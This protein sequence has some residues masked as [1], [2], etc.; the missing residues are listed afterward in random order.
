MATLPNTSSLS[1]VPRDTLRE[2]GVVVG[3][4]DG[5]TIDVLLEDGKVYR[6][7]YIGIDT[8]D[9][10]DPGYSSSASVNQDL[11]YGKKVT[12]VKDVSNIDKYDRLLRYVIVGDI[13]VNYEIVYKGYAYSRDY[14][15]DLAC[16][17]TFDKAESYANA[18]NLGMWAPEPTALPTFPSRS[19]GVGDVCSCSG[20]IYNCSDFS[21]HSQAQACYDYCKDQGHG[22]VHRLDSDNDGSACETLP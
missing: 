17:A 19:G 14:Y 11:V 22:D 8:P 7:R 4:I 5:D 6:V 13:F 15:P 1:C 9:Q 12:L 20:N 10:G 21:T 16:S 2:V 3:V 18:N